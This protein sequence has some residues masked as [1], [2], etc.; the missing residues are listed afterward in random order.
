MIAVY[1]SRKLI[2]LLNALLLAVRHSALDRAAGTSLIN[3][4]LARS[5]FIGVLAPHAFDTAASIKLVTHS[6]ISFDHTFKL[7][8]QIGV[9]TCEAR[10][11]L[12]ESF[13]LCGQV[14]TL[15][16]VLRLGH[17]EGLDITS[18]HRNV[19]LLIVKADLVVADRDGEIGVAALAGLDLLPE[20]IVL[21]SDTVIVSPQGGVLAAQLVVFLVSSTEASLSVG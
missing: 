21:S 17:S 3:S 7:N 5:E 9:L 13:F 15:I 11:V 16:L 10:S 1:W 6:F 8:G 14:G 19:S 18:E 12:L 4:I 20:V 2:F